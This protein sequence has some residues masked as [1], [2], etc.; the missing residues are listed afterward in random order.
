MLLAFTIC[1]SVS[2]CGE[3]G[4]GIRRGGGR[5]EQ[6]KAGGGGGRIGE[7]AGRTAFRESDQMREREREREP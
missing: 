5:G 3:G 1:C 4:S 7:P 2:Q 6:L